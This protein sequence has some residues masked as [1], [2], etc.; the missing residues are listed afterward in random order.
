MRAAILKQATA[1]LVLAALASPTPSRAA[2]RAA[3]TRAE[4]AWT[5]H[6]SDTWQWQLSGTL[7]TAYNVAVY[8][9]DLFETPLPTIAALHARGIHVVCYFSAGSGE[10]WRPDY[11]AFAKT[12]LGHPLSGWAGER[13]LDTRSKTVRAVMTRRLDLAVAKGCDGVEPDNV[14]A[15]QNHPGFA[16]TANTQFD[17]NRF[18]AHAAH[19]RG[20]AVAL[21]NDVDQVAALAPAFDFALNEQ[22]HEYAECGAYAAFATLGKAVFNAEYSSA[23]VKNTRGARDRLCAASKA[24]GIR[25]LVLPLLLDDKFRIACD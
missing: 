6:A 11:A 4:A 8:D 13:W 17:Y 12:D 23:Y 3:G 9:I 24:A 10:N 20:L 16:L 14:D 25:T 21:K 7:D 1:A 18:L 15:F 19:D 5:P 22:C 2:T